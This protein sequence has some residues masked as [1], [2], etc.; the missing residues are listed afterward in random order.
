MTT[1]F[2]KNR[3]MAVVAKMGVMPGMG[4]IAISHFREVNRSVL[5]VPSNPHGHE[6]TSPAFR[7]NKNVAKR[8]GD[9][10]V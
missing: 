5:K 6:Q 7:Q 8:D 9:E 3:E 4:R 2:S 1:G 10:G